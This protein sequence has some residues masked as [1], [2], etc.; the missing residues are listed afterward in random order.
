MGEDTLAS[1]CDDGQHL[2][3]A[4]PGQNPLFVCAPL[5]LKLLVSMQTPAWP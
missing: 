3:E 1:F 4:L 5:Q 2:I